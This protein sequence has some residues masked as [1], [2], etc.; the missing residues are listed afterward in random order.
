MVKTCEINMTVALIEEIEK[1]PVESTLDHQVNA[2]RAKYEQFSEEGLWNLL[3]LKLER[4]TLSNIPVD[5]QPIQALL[6]TPKRQ[7][8][9]W[10]YVTQEEFD[11]ERVAAIHRRVQLELAISPIFGEDAPQFV[12]LIC[13]NLLPPNIES[14]KTEDI[15]EAKK[16]TITFSKEQRTGLGPKGIAYLTGLKQKKAANQSWLGRGMQALKDKAISAALQSINIQGAKEI[17]VL[18]D[19][20]V[21]AL[22]F[23]SG[24]ITGR[25]PVGS[26]RTLR[27]IAY[28]PETRQIEV[29][30]DTMSEPHKTKTQ[31]WSADDFQ[32]TFGD[33]KWPSA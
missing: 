2:L 12:P 15:G 26:E 9:V 3:F 20:R 7:Q 31:H 14:V 8:R 21:N 22:M 30:L 10:E 28:D 1:L 27:V 18:I 24:H 5:G 11:E 29:E 13:R 6:D 16:L 33:L 32:R 4:G 23:T 17:V 19:P 25:A